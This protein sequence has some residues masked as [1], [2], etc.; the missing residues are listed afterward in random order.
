[1]LEFFGDIFDWMEQI[2]PFWAY[3]AILT[4]A[5]GE[6]VIPPVPG[7]MVVVYGGYLAGIGRLD[8]ALVVLLSTIGGAAGFMT[9]YAIG[10]RVGDRV[11][12]K[13]RLRWLPKAR[14]ER[15]QAWLEH[16]GYWVVGLNRFLS[17]ARSIISLTVG[18]ARLDTTKTTLCASASAFVWTALISYG[19]VQLGEN[20]PLVG[21]YLRAYGTI[22]LISVSVV[23]AFML[24]RYYVQWRKTVR[25]RNEP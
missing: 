7:D 18:M 15:A 14:I 6:N 16:W 5:Y 12:E 8:F 4:I 2:P 10:H 21:E 1:M 22:V 11:L 23:L 9:M 13:H 19:G 20:W 3:V 25:R 24:G 17:G